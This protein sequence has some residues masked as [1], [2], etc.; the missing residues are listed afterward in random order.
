MNLNVH[1]HIQMCI[2]ASGLIPVVLYLR[3]SFDGSD[4]S[5]AVFANAVLSGQVTLLT[6]IYHVPYWEHYVYKTMWSII[7]L[8]S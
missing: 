4:M 5:Q 8:I 7:V 3:V 1:A 6:P 2:Y